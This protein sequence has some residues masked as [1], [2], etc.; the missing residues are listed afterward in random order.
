MLNLKSIHTFIKEELVMDKNINL[1]NLFKKYSYS[2][3]KALGR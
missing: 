1:Y 2:Q 3:L